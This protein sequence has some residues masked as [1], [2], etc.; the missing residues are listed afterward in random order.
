L[1]R[2]L[3]PGVGELFDVTR[4]PVFFLAPAMFAEPYDFSNEDGTY[5]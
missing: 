1:A 3:R 5:A 2:A 4:P